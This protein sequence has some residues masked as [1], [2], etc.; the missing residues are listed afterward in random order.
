MNKISIGTP[1]HGPFDSHQTMLLCMLKY[2]IRLQV[3]RVARVGLVCFD[4]AN[5]LAA[6]E[7]PFLQALTHQHNKNRYMAMETW[8]L[9]VTCLCLLLT[10]KNC[11]ALRE[12]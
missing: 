5:V 2:G 8:C 10:D 6:T 12:V 9:R 11:S 1:S 3:F 4:P 7:A